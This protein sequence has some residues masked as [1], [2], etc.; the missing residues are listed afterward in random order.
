[1][2]IHFSSL[3][4]LL[5]FQVY[6]RDESEMSTM[7]KNLQRSG[8][9]AFYATYPAFTLCF[10]LFVFSAV[11]LFIAVPQS[12]QFLFVNRLHHPIGDAAFQY[13]TYGGDGLFML[14]LAV[15][16]LFV[17][18]KY[19]V[20]AVACFV[21]TGLVA[22]AIKRATKLPRPAKVFAG[23]HD[24]YLPQDCVVHFHNSFPSGHTTTAFAMMALLYYLFPNQRNSPF[25]FVMALLVGYSRIY[26]VQ[27]FPQDVCA[28]AVIGSLLTFFLIWWFDNS[29]LFKA[30]W[31]NRR[32]HIS[33]AKCKPADAVST[34]INP[35]D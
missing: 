4:D 6:F 22:Q 30:G 11:V 15:I 28:G 25:L 10:L 21:L 33:V 1:M 31:A 9:L 24:I 5:V 16:L 26:L 18:F 29:T 23:S 7:V 34:R 19:V 3:N 14:L 12:D 13:I 20:Y 35:A 8:A 32:L 17:R 27:H 2:T